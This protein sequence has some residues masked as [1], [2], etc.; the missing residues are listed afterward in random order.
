MLTYLEK[1]PVEIVDRLYRESLLGNVH[2]RL[3]VEL[4]RGEVVRQRAIKRVLIKRIR[5][6]TP[7]LRTTGIIDFFSASHS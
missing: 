2:Q 6:A 1:E 4:F 3:H 7:L 5:T